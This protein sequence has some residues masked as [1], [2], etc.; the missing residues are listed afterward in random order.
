[1]VGKARIAEHVR[2][3]AAGDMTIVIDHEI[4]GDD[5]IAFR[6]LIGLGNGKQIIEHVICELSGGKIVRQV[7]V[8]A[9][10]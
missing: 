8:E 2:M 6:V 1:M 7:D 3:V 10:D 5:R 4:T 9:W